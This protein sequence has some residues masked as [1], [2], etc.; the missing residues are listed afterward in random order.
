MPLELIEYFKYRESIYEIDGVLICQDRIL[1]PPNLREDV[2]DGLH[3]AHHG[4]DGMYTHA[5]SRVIW[6]GITCDTERTRKE[7]MTCNRNAP[8]NPRQSPEEPTIPSM[9]FECIGADYFQLEGHHYL[10]AVDRMSGWCEVFQAKSGT[11]QAG[12]KGLL[13]ALRKLF[14]C[15]GVPLE[16]SSDEGTEFT[17]SETKDFL[18]RWGVKHRESSAHHP[19]SNG[20]AELG[21]KS[22]KRL[23]RDNVG[24]GGSL[25]NDCFHR[26]L[27]T[28]RN[29]PDPMSKKSPAEVL[30]G[31]KL[32]DSLPMFEGEKDLHINESILPVWRE[33]WKMKEQALRAR[34][35]KSIEKLSE[36]SKEL[37]PL[38][39]EDRV[40]V[41]NQIGNHPTK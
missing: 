35:V 4:T 29:T 28:H 19:S 32:R 8:S 30:F 13:A 5:S 39:Q 23:L 18:N 12:S 1:I 9:P 15:F 24:P 3:A 26:A 6:P 38:Q 7:C 41:Q 14:G 16:I 34:A 17:A 22:I 10:V 36:H 40:L 25:N 37:P 11:V 21:V 20:R 33:G 2:L 31:H 27:L